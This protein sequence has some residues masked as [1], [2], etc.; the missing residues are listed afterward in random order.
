MGKCCIT[1]LSDLVDILGTVCT[2][3][4]NCRAVMRSD[5]VCLYDTAACTLHDCFILK[6]EDAVRFVVIYKM[7]LNGGPCGLKWGDA[8]R[9]GIRQA[10][11]SGNN[12][13]K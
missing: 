13:A 12:M 2:P 4:W 5:S 11:I 1:S 3:K 7:G 8:L 9:L 6:K 10:V